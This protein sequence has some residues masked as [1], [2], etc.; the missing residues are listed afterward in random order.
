MQ[1][2]KH[3]KSSLLAKYSL[4]YEKNPKSRVFAPLAES[5][6]KL[7][8]LDEAFKVLKE[9]IKRHPTYVMGYIVLS[10]CYFDQQNYELAYN[11]IRPFVSDNLENISLQKLFAQ[12]CINLGYLEEALQ[13]FKYLLLINP[14]DQYVSEQVKLLEDDLLV[15]DQEE[16]PSKTEKFGFEEDEDE[17]VQVNFNK[18]QVPEKEDDLEEWNVEAP[19]KE[20]LSAF[21]SE[22]EKAKLD[23]TERDIDDEYFYEEYDNED[24]P[25]EYVEEEKS[26]DPIIT[27]T[28]VDLYIRQGHP[29]KAVEIL[30]SII[31]LH[32]NDRASLNKLNE[33]KGQAQDTDS[34]PFLKEVPE[35]AEQEESDDLANLVAQRVKVGRERS[36]K[37]LENK[38]TIFLQKIKKA[39]KEKLE[40]A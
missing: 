20:K 37:E 11:T 9:G 7:G 15:N 28:L 27:H 8:M 19:V 21:K 3:K 5:Y 18:T 17:W 13:T 6:R 23:I 32:P 34:R 39:S 35:Q 24:E 22:V 38:L 1:N 30:E 25:K 16:E 14:R 2:N 33:L 12:I 10:H 26:V 40:M 36:L 29:E 4:L 31:E